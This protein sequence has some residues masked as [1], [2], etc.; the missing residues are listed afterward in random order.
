MSVPGR[1]GIIL[2]VILAIFDGIILMS[3]AHKAATTSELHAVS[4]APAQTA[5]QDTVL[6]DAMH[7]IALLRDRAKLHI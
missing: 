2:I 4:E 1:I 7:G 5:P 6:S 3:G